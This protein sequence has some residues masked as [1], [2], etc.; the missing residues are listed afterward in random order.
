MLLKLLPGKKPNIIYQVTPEKAE[1]E[2]STGSVCTR[3]PE[4]SQRFACPGNNL[5]FSYNKSG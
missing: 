4:F 1:L 2:K 5:R 3:L